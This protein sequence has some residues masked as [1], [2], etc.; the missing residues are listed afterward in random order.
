MVRG[1]IWNENG[2]PEGV[3]NGDE[4]GRV[5]GQHLTEEGDRDLPSGVM[6]QQ[7]CI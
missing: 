1:D 2:A 3:D 6:Q 7:A 4:G 5:H